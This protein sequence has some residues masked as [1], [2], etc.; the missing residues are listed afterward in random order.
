M[1]D[2]VHHLRGRNPEEKK[3]NSAWD[4]LGLRVGWGLG[5]CASY[6]PCLPVVCVFCFSF[7]LGGG[8]GWNNT[9][10]GCNLYFW[11]PAIA[12]AQNQRE[13]GGRENRDKFG[14]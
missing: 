13:I 11:Y 2:A 4:P 10:E 14:V 6:F 3:Q 5:K 7:F 9:Q 1:G 12:V 8:P